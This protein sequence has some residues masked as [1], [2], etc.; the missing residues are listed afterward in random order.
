MHRQLFQEGSSAVAQGAG[1]PPTRTLPSVQSSRLVVTYPGRAPH[2]GVSAG[3]TTSGS[4]P[5]WPCVS[6]S[7]PLRRGASQSGSQPARL[8]TESS[9]SFSNHLSFAGS[10][11]SSASP[12]D[13]HSIAGS[14]RTGTAL[15]AGGQ[16]SSLPWVCSKCSSVVRCHNC[17]PQAC[18]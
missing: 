18:T 16:P 13:H 7:V 4:Q 11:R 6:S 3:A 8:C 5:V 10:H 17:S 14:Q 15:A 1:L 12:N 9:A 2:L